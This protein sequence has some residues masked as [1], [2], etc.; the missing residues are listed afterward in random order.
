MESL[1]P[2][3]L[4]ESRVS[5]FLDLG[6]NQPLVTTPPIA[7]T[8]PP[9][10]S[11]P[12]ATGTPQTT[13]PTAPL[14]PV[15]TDQQA[16]ILRQALDMALGS[17]TDT[18]P[19][20]LGNVA[21]INAGLPALPTKLLQR[22]W[23]KEFVDFAEIPPAKNRQRTLPNDLEGRVLIVHMHEL[24]V[25]KKT[26]PDFTT[27]AQCFA[28]YAAAI[29]QKQ[30]G[31]AAD[32]MA[33]FFATANNARKYKWPSWVVYDQNFR[34]IMA[35]NQ[36]TVWAKTIPALFTECFIHAQKSQESWCKRCHAIEHT[37]SECPYTTAASGQ[38]SIGQSSSRQYTEAPPSEHKKGVICRDYNGAKGKGCKWGANCYRHH[39]CSECRGA[40]PKFKC[41]NRK[42]EPL[43][44]SHSKSSRPDGQ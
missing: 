43:P 2:V 7:S 4:L 20:P 18:Q 5:Q 16:D 35:E 40:H 31:R 36:D 27:W 30:P 24:E 34:Q 25:T 33:Y 14:T 38:S 29:L 6:A 37:T 21:S 8:L 22:I 12:Q 23:A 28:V 11:V 39:I 44:T 26:I 41:P 13:W 17:S 9:S 19:P 15:A 32:L 1:P 42:Q 3:S 10:S